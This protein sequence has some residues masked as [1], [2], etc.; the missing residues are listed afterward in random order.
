MKK[1]LAGACC[2]HAICHFHIPVKISSTKNNAYYMRFESE[3]G[4]WT[5]L[6]VAIGAPVDVG[7]RFHLFLWKVNLENDMTSFRDLP[8]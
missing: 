4:C 2:K 7:I 5:H 3:R 8:R 6:F 1:K